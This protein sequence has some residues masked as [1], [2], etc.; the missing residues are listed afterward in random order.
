MAPEQESSGNSTLSPSAAA[1]GSNGGANPG[2]GSG[3]SGTPTTRHIGPRPGQFMVSSRQVP[4]LALLSDDVIAQSLANAPGVEIV[5]TIKPPTAL[6]LQ[7]ADSTATGSMIVA[8]MTHDRAQLLQSQAGARLVVEHDAPLTF[9]LDP[10][11]QLALPNPGVIIPFGNG[12]K[13]VIEVHGPNGPLAGADVFVFGTMLPAQGTTDAS[14][15]A[16][17]SVTG[18]SPDTIRAIYVKPKTDHWDLWIQSPSLVPDSV[19]TVVV[20]PLGAL[21]TGFPERQL[22]GWGQRAMGLD[23]MPASYDGAGIKIAIV[24]SGAAQTTHRNLNKVGPGFDVVGN[25]RNTW[26]NDTVGHGSHVAGVVGGSAAGSGVRGFAPAA[27]IHVLRIFPGARFSDLVGALDY[28]VENGID[29][30]NMSLGGGEPSKIVEERLIKAKSMGVACIIAAGNSGGP[31]QFPASTPHALAVSAIGKQGEFPSDSF[32]ATQPLAGFE[33]RQGYFPAKFSCFGPEIDV[34]APG[35][36]IV[37]S[38]PPDDFGAWDGTSMAAPHVTGLAA[39]VLA[40]HPD[41]KG[42]VPGP[43]RQSGGAAFPDHQADGDTDAD[44]RQHPGWGWDAE[45]GTSPRSASRPGRA[46]GF[47]GTAA[48]RRSR[49]SGAKAL[50]RGAGDP[51]SRRSD[52]S[53]ND[54]RACARVNRLRPEPSGWRYRHAAFGSGQRR[55]CPRS[56]EEGGVDIT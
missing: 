20:K 25:N 47:R 21:L 31:V 33:N 16:N 6:G 24:D 13:T 53:G 45:R 38:L 32:H 51:G 19:N 9:G 23:Q 2:A 28:C 55:R 43:Q 48:G 40:H 12:F 37:S 11:P 52:R 44:R 10:G 35:V 39:L 15:R 34:C 50:P 7:S 18:E 29:V 26:T 4:G 42:D 1:A 54:R 27:E 56:A 17:I 3:A 41:F 49:H 30:V 36:A 22:L 5:K 46:P 8:R 14:G